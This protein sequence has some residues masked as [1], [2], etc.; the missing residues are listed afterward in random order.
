VT[1]EKVISLAYHLGR[2]VSVVVPF[3]WVFV[4]YILIADRMVLAVV[5]AVR[6]SE[7]T[8]YFAEA[9]KGL[10]R[11]RY[12]QVAEVRT[13]CDA[14]GSDLGLPKGDAQGGGMLEKIVWMP[15][16]EPM[17]RMVPEC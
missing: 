9:H 12:A 17:S 15:S 16:I 10:E 3:D 2:Q 1:N 5:A 13:H 4:E 7:E 14:P 8:P 11:W 6:G